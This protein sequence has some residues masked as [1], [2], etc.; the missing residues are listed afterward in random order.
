MAGPWEKYATAEGPWLKYDAPKATVAGVIGDLAAGAVR[1]AGSIGATIL[2]PIDAAAR[3][4]NDGKPVNVGGFDIVG[5]DR[6]AGMDAALQELGADTGSAAFQAGK[7]GAEVAGTAGVGGAL[8]RGAA[9]LPG[10][11][12]AAPVIDAIRSAGMTAGGAT[13]AG[14]MAARAAGGALAGGASAALVN[15]ED[16][17]AGALIGAALPGAVSLAAKGGQAASKALRGGVQTPETAAAVRTAQAAGYVIPPTQANPTLLNRIL[18]GTAGKITTAQN[19]SARNQAVTNELA[20]RAIGLPKGT[21][22]TPE[23]LQQ[24]RQTAGQAYDAVASIGQLTPGQAYDNALNKLAAQ[25]VTAAKGFPNAKPSPVLE[26]VESLRSPSFDASS[27]VAKIK[28]LRASADDAYR[29]GASDV[30]KA[31]KG[32]AGALEDVIEAHLKATGQPD[33][34]TAFRDSRKLIAKTYTVEK[35]LNAAS[36]SVDAKKLARELQKGKPLS[37][38]LKT[39][40]EFAS[41]FPKAAQTPETM[42]SLPQMSPLDVG[43]AGVM[44]TV[45]QSPLAF[46]GLA[47]RPLARTA[48]LSGPVQSGL[49]QGPGLLSSIPAGAV[50]PI[51]RSAP[52][53]G[54]SS[55]R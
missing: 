28:E 14:G 22:I 35:A 26:L 54:A 37:A 13:G 32:A 31:M 42:G 7:L 29:S 24:V 47:A 40:A 55:D 2:A 19:A 30:G 8:A 50:A 3:A 17:G 44:S 9:L 4:L 52:V 43:A 12:R 11:A 10:A 6:R 15:P 41:R 51:Y 46:A 1:G 53:I 49:V 18:E 33:L 45:L 38:E 25:A 48:A 39:A 36:G 34:L 23:V 5:Q 20:A 27:A 16:A 21:Q